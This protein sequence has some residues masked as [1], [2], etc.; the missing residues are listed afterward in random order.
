MAA[1]KRV[2]LT[3]K[4]NSVPTS[5][6]DVQNQMNKFDN[7][8]TSTKLNDLYKEF[9]SITFGTDVVNSTIVKEN[10]VAETKPYA[11][12]KTTVYLTAAVIVTILLAFL[13]IY[14][15]FVINNLNSNI[16]L[17]QGDVAEAQSQLET[18]RL[19]NLQ[20]TQQEMEQ[21]IQGTL[22]GNYGDIATNGAIAVELLK[23]TPQV[24][25]EVETNWFDQVCTF[26]SSIFGG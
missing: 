4:A 1:Y 24:E 11:T 22:S 25:P 10:V 12:L 13:A 7:T 14:N 6:D 8:Y 17:L 26:V 2:V 20:L 16:Q 23:V 18:V 3:E 15:I 9:D 19:E 5:N 21:L